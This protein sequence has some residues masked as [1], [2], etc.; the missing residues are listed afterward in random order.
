LRLVNG[1]LTVGFLPLLLRIYN[2]NKK[3]FYL[4]WGTG[5]FLYGVHIVVRVFLPLLGLEASTNV[6]LLSYFVQLTGFG[7][8]IVGIGD[9]VDRTRQLL[10]P[11][12]LGR[13]VSVAPYLYIA[14]ALI[15]IKLFYGVAIEMLIIGWFILLI[16]NLG[17]ALDLLTPTFLE[18][19]A[20]NAK[21]VLLY[22]YL[23][24]DLKRFLISGYPKQYNE[25]KRGQLILV[26]SQG[27]TKADEIRYMKKMTLEG[28]TSGTRTILVSMYDVVSQRDMDVND[29]DDGLYFIRVIQGAQKNVAFSKQKVM[30]ITDDPSAVGMLLMEVINFSKE[31]KSSC[32]VILYTLSSMIHVHGV[33]RVYSM[34]TS[35]LP[36]LKNSEV[37]LYLIY[38]SKTHSEGSGVA[39]L[40]TLADKVTHI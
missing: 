35:R 6:K 39:I 2:R 4:L 14:L 10:Y 13:I 8:I 32:Q 16:A 9:L 20:I 1:L 5:F 21:A 24:D 3:R 22:G 28:K 26:D 12:L 17:Q 11:Y 27:T 33:Q 37:N 23:V 7:L 40:E 36:E 25:E 18:V 29:E 38:N 19:L 31:T 15:I 30:T 34:M